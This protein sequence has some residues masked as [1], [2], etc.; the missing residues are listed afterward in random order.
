MGKELKDELERI[1]EEIY[2]FFMN[3]AARKEDAKKIADKLSH[4]FE[5]RKRKVQADK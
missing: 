1:L 2:P 4:E 5:I 3:P